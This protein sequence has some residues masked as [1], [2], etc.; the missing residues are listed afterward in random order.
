MAASVKYRGTWNY[1]VNDRPAFNAYSFLPTP[2]PVKPRSKDP[3][4]EVEEP[5]P[6]DAEEA[7]PEVLY[8]PPDDAAVWL[9]VK[10]RF[11]D[12]RGY[13]S[14]EG[15][16][17]NNLGQTIGFINKDEGTAGSADEEYLGSA[18]EQLSGNEV[19]VE[20]A[21]DERCGIVDL[22]TAA[23]K[24]NQGSTVAEMASN[25]TLTGNHGSTLG[26]VEGF[27]YHD[28]RTVALYVMLIDPGMLNE[29]EDA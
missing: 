6:E 27:E 29:Q 16:C 26:V 28:M 2:P 17:V 21:V 13:I 5:P 11:M 10:D 23:I 25:G 20:D 4:P 15:E 7:P 3:P 12:Y 18:Q 1:V 19:V 8:E 22:G 24:D 9:I 14:E